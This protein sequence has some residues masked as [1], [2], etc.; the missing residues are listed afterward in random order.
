MWGRIKPLL[1]ANSFTEDFFR[2]VICLVPASRRLGKHF[3]KWYH[4]FQES[5]K[6]SQT[7]LTT[8]QLEQIN[9]LCKKVITT[10]PF[11]KKRFESAGGLP[12]LSLDDFQTR[13]STLSRNEFRANYSQILSPH[14]QLS[15]FERATTSG[16]TGN[17]LQFFH[18]AQDVEREWAAI[19]YQW[20]RVGFD[21]LSSRRV[22]FRGLTRPGSLVQSFPDLRML[23]CSILNINET[24][25]PFFEEQIRAFKGDFF[26]GYPSA[27]YLLARSVL[28]SNIQFPQP[29]GILLA[30]EMVYDFQIAEIEAAFPKAKIFAHYGCA[31]RSILA[32]WCEKSREY[33]I[34]PQY[35]LVERDQHTHEL[36]GTNMYNDTNAFLRY[37]MTDTASEFVSEKCAE[38][39]RPYIRFNE[40]NG[41]SED[42]LWSPEKGWIPPAIVTYPLKKLRVIRE[43]QILQNEKGA[44]DIYYLISEQSADLLAKDMADI[45]TGLARLFGDSMKLR[46]K[47]VDEIHRGATGKFK[48]IINNLDTKI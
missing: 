16:T 6:W 24:T 33:H 18:S 29:Q 36:I 45:Q 43:I 17:A 35:S 42:F 21:P 8:F 30:S 41:R 23:R 19:C 25:L 14:I 15:K 37:R 2:Q 39:E 28:R 47:E 4:F 5:E 12:F 13:L 46:F 7:D 31:E 22:E 40:I 26:H 34:L 44:L 11:Y 9:N 32:G 48:W 10:S 1:K 38:C 20:K 3:W 27:L